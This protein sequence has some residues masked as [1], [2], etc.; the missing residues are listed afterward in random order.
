MKCPVLCPAK[1]IGELS[2]ELLLL[3]AGVVR[4][5]VTFCRKVGLKIIGLVENMAEFVCPCC[6]V[7]RLSCDSLLTDGWIVS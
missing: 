6:E 2:C 1:N 7:S 4:R 5:Q 3:L